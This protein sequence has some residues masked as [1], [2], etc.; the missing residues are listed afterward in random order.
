[1]F[2]SITLN[3]DA[4]GIRLIL[5]VMPD[6]IPEVNSV[7]LGIAAICCSILTTTFGV[8]QLILIQFL[9]YSRVD[10]V[11]VPCC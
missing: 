4:M 2:I 8:M 10:I 5:F 11:A 3:P 9:A 1:M 6:L 7:I